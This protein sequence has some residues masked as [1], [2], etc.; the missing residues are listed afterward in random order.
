VL[1]VN[2]AI[3][4]ICTGAVYGLVALGYN[5]VYGA[6]GVFNV[7]QGD[8]VMV[9]VMLSYVTLN[10]AKLPIIVA[11]ILVLIGVALLSVVEERVV[12]RPFLRQRGSFGWF[13]STLGFSI[14][15][16]AIARNWYGN[17]P[18]AAIPSPVTTSGIHIGGLLLVP[19]ELVILGLLI[20][21]AFGF[22]LLYSRTKVGRAMRA[23]AEDREIAGLRG[24][25]PN[26][27]ARIG[28]ALGGVIA[29]LAGFAV[30]PLVGADP[31]VGLG[32]ALK[33]FVAL[34]IGGFGNVRAGMLAA[35]LLGAVE[36]ESDLYI[37]AN[38]EIAVGLVLLVVVL[39]L[40]PTGLGR[41]ADNL[42]QV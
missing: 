9:G 32:Y 3:A 35:L 6:T 36:K 7:A 30:A 40:R 42:R 23:T 29:A 22:E 12:V 17:R 26:K 15:I 21:L 14:V 10:V 5:I 20:V 37:G 41:S 34:A 18:T 33:G 19:R 39:L 25:D 11:L 24:I 28:F 13:I 2:A 8:L 27:M 38:Y 4:G 31:T 16:E 1:P